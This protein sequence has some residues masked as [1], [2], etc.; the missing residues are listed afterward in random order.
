MKRVVEFE[1]W[2]KPGRVVSQDFGKEI[3]E[4]IWSSGIPRAVFLGVSNIP[5]AGDVV[6]L[7][8]LLSSG[9]ADLRSFGEFCLLHGLPVDLSDERSASTY[10]A[11]INGACVAWIHLPEDSDIPTTLEELRRVLTPYDLVIV[12]V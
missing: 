12:D 8:K 1:A 5:A 2:T 11:Y 7:R 4:E 6:A 9:N 10:L 3:Q